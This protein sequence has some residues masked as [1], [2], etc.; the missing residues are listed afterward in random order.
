[1]FNI[2]P[3]RRGASY[4]ERV[5]LDPLEKP[6]SDFDPA[7]N[8]ILA[9]HYFGISPFRSIGEVAAEIVAQLR[10]RRQVERVHAL[11]PRV[12][13]ELLAEIAVERSIR[14][15]VERKLDRF[16]GLD[17]DALNAT[18]GDQFPPT[19]LHLVSP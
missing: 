10:F 17:P 8:P 3:P 4:T 11:G 5:A 19:P 15:I 13:A 6:P 7:A 1:M 12:L 2:T 16:A 9:K 14:V 18:G